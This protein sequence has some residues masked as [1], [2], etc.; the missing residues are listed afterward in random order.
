MIDTL[1]RYTTMMYS[2]ELNHIES[3]RDLSEWNRIG[4]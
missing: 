4:S 2:F 1:Y 3:N